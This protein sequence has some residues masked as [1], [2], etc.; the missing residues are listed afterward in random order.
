LAITATIGLL[1]YGLI[2]AGEG[3]WTAVETIVPI[4]LALIAGL[5]FVLIE[6]RATSPLLPLRTLARPRLAGALHVLVSFSAL[7]GGAIFLGSLYAQR[8]LGLSALET[9]LT[10]VPFA[11]AVII[12]AQGGAHA[13]GHF[14][15]HRIGAIGLFLAAIGAGL[16]SQISADGDVLTD[17]LPGLILLALGLGGT[18]VAASTSAFIGVTEADAGVTSGLVNTSHELGIA[19]GVSILSTIAGASLAADPS[20]V[21]G[22]R[23]AFLAAAI[24]A[25]AIAILAYRA[26]PDEAPGGGSFVH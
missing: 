17:L 16:L 3:G 7:L 25:A 4:G 9:G 18:A 13:I 11:V 23:A 1:L 5:A 20:V 26:L 6:R 21:S 24:A 12:G 15:P 10:F 19:I 2:S 22:Y 8:T 14:G